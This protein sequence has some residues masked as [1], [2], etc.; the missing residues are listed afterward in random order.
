MDRILYFLPALACPIGMGVM[1]W[2]MMRPKRQPADQPAPNTQAQEL[3]QLRS[4]IAALRTATPGSHIA[5]AAAPSMTK[6]YT[7]P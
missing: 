1:M 3:T 7:A 2:L 6:H 5:T 4:E